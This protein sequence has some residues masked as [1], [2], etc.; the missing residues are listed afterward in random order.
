MRKIFKNLLDKTKAI[1]L[2][3]FLSQSKKNYSDDLQNIRRMRLAS[4]IYI[5]YRNLMVNKLRSFLTIAGVSV[6]IGIVTFLICIGFGVQKMI[7]N[8]VTK[9]NP[10]DVI[11]VNNKKLDNFVSLNEKN[12][13]KIKKINGVEDIATKVN[14][15]GKIYFDNYQTDVIIYGTTKKYFELSNIPVKYGTIDL[16]DN[17]SKVAIST[18]AASILG[19]KN[20]KDIIGKS[21]KFDIILSRE[22][23]SDLKE[24]KN[25]TDNEAE[26]VAVID[27]NN[28][29]VWFPSC[30]LKD[31]FKIDL[32]QEGKVKIKSTDEA[33]MSEI[34][35]NIEVLGF[36]TESV[37][38]VINDINSFFWGV[39]IVLI[40]FGVIIMSISAMGMLNTLS[41]S[42]L[43]RT[44]EVGILKALGA[45]R[46]DIFKM[47][48]LEAA[49]I[50]FLGGIIGF[51]GGYG[52]AKIFNIFFNLLAHQRNLE[53]VA[54]IYIPSYFVI[55]L[56][57]FIAFLGLVTGI[58]PAR[59]AAYIHALDALRYE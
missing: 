41:V 26:V 45:K 57:A 9:K 38:D 43:Q 56:V 48:I 34:R 28:A 7:V 27:D 52:L 19:F 53:S 22:T 40:I 1:F 58:G 12:V 17:A 51:F 21:I 24:E 20:P 29:I 14:T 11:N 31:K 8:E 35:K 10:I 59:R 16:K 23:N 32:A 18:K 55:A 33:K 13:E 39:K 15:G 46:K 36:N 49:I 5:S 54:F 4:V 6:G 42:L 3:L 47:F 44:K 37:I 25:I 50:S 2:K 30:C